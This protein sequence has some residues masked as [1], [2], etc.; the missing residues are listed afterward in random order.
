M[1][2]KVVY[3][4]RAETAESDA[5][6]QKLQAAGYRPFVLPVLSV[7]WLNI[8]QLQ[9]AL[10]H[11]EAYSGL[12]FTSA[13]A[14]EAVCRLKTLPDAWRQ[15]PVYV[16]G[17]RTAAAIR[18]IGWSPQG[19]EAGVGDKLARLILQAP[20]PTQPLLF[21]CGTRRR[22]E[23]PVLLREAGWPL[24][25]LVVYD[26]R[27]LVPVLPAEPPDWVVFFS[28]SGLEAIRQLPFFWKQTRVAAIGPTTAAALQQ[29]GIQVDAVAWA[30][31]PEGLLAAMQNAMRRS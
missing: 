29:E 24:E 1:V 22:N 19:E 8:E 5:F 18:K 26:T 20:R 27:P 31:T 28:P 23:L 15:R 30:P 2:G 10:A 7:A 3:L 9:A 11:P 4:L 6:A 17:P 16:V 21:L 25:E 12:I 14:V 13:R